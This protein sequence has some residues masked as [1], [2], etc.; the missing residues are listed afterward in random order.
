[1]LESPEMW[2]RQ[3]I[4]RNCENLQQHLN[5]HNIHKTSTWILGTYNKPY[6]PIF[7]YSQPFHNSR[8]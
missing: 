1:M 8:N 2:N 4:V 5:R 3:S 7:S 6:S